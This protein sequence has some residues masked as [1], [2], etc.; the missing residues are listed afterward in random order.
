MKQMKFYK[1]VFLIFSFLFSSVIKAQTNDLTIEEF[2]TIQIENIKLT[3]IKATKGNEN[4]M[5]SFFENL[6]IEKGNE[7]SHWVSYSS[8]SLFFLFQDGLLVDNKRVYQITDI[9]I[10]DTSICLKIKGIE[11][12]I[13][14]PISILGDVNFLTYSDGITRITYKLGAQVIR[15]EFDPDSKLITGIKYQYYNT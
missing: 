1:I 12:R 2:L 7:P 14:D 4:S 15:I 6:S 8:N 13:G 11:V 9:S 10:K 3:E 5:Q